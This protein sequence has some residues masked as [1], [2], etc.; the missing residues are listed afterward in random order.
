MVIILDPQDQMRWGKKNKLDKEVDW[1]MLFSHH[2]PC[3][4]NRTFVLFRLRV[5]TR[6]TGLLVGFILLVIFAHLY[7]IEITTVLI[8]SIVLPL[9]AIL[10]FTLTEL[11][12]KRNNGIKRFVTGLLLGIV[13]GLAIE[14]FIAGAIFIGVLI[15]LWVVSLEFIVA[16]IL[17]K[18]NVLNSF[19]RQY[20]EGVYKTS[21]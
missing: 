11:G 13:L 17:H 16:I 8:S 12:K 1:G 4:Y 19:M 5:C 2:P 9:P 3:Q 10:N 14:Q 18:A 7:L 15:L 20:E 21:D 6:C